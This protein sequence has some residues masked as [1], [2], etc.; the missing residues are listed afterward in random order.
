MVGLNLDLAFPATNRCGGNASDKPALMQDAH[1]DTP[2]Y[3]LFVGTK[4]IDQGRMQICGELRH[5]FQAHLPQFKPAGQCLTEPSQLIDIELFCLKGFATIHRQRARIGCRYQVPPRWGGGN[6]H[7]PGLEQ[8]E[9]RQ[10]IWMEWVAR[11]E[12]KIE[13][14]EGHTGLLL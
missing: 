14:G 9:E 6:D 10:G 5:L 12:T 8:L 7:I 2:G 1:A 13:Y 3:E 11:E 4:V